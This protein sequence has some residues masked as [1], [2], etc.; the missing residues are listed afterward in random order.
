MNWIKVVEALKWMLTK[1]HTNPDI[2]KVIAKRLLA[3]RFWCC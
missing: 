2:I 3:L 1:A